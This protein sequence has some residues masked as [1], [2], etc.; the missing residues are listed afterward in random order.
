MQISP[1][2]FVLQY[3]D[4]EQKI[5]ASEEKEKVLGLIE[6]A[7]LLRTGREKEMVAEQ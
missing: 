3:S 2:E 7:S 5:I 6:Q 4:S 1:S